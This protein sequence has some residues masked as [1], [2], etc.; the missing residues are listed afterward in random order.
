MRFAQAAFCS[1]VAP[2]GLAACPRRRLPLSAL[3]PGAAAGA[4]ELVWLGLGL[5]VGLG[6]RVGVGLRVGVGAG[7]GLGTQPHL[8]PVT[9]AA[10]SAA[11]P[12]VAAL[13]AHALA[14]SRRRLVRVYD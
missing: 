10:Q 9:A 12:P 14:R 1:P 7:F 3:D 11:R 8:A 2:R 6:V 5:A 4:A 13:A